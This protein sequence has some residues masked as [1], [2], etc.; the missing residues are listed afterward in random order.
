MINE[1]Q[2]GANHNRGEGRFLSKLA[3]FIARRPLRT[4]Q[5]SGA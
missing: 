2:D 4:K 3:F 5:P 1:S